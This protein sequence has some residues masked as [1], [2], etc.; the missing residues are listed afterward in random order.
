MRKLTTVNGTDLYVPTC[1]EIR[2]YLRPHA[3]SVIWGTPDLVPEDK[4]RGGIRPGIGGCRGTGGD[5]NQLMPQVGA[6]VAPNGSPVYYLENEEVTFD[7][8]QVE[9]LKE[10]GFAPEVIAV[11]NL[12]QARFDALSRGCKI[13]GCDDYGPSLDDV[14]VNSRSDFAWCMSKAQVRSIVGPTFAP[15]E[16]LVPDM[17][18]ES[19]NVELFEHVRGNSGQAVFLKTDNNEH[20]GVGVTR[21]TTPAEF[22][23]A[24]ARI[25]ADTRT[26]ELKKRLIVQQGCTGR[27]K[28]FTMFIRP[29]DTNVYVVAVTDQVADEKTSQALGNRLE[30]LTDEN[31]LPIAELMTTIAQNMKAQCPNAFGFVMVDYVVKPDGSIVAFDPGLR[32]SAATPGAMLVL[33]AHE[34]TGKWLTV[35]SLF[36]FKAKQPNLTW[37]EICKALPELTDPQKILSTSRG[38]FPFGIAPG[39]NFGNCGRLMFMGESVQACAEIQRHVQ[40]ILPIAAR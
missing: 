29:N 20:A 35:D 33:W 14:V 26:Y 6:Y 38:V 40:S 9:W 39:E 25:R 23:E 10:I 18:A 4:S 32:M 37:S 8:S 13:Y 19:T 1:S 3:T 17:F 7:R 11:P 5:G 31:V 16:V 30:P 15:N 2:S 27:F 24:L 12:Q 22:N 36:W 28:S 34:Q 21:V